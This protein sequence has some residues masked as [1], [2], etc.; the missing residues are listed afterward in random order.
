L[1]PKPT[2]D[3]SAPEQIHPAEPC[4]LFDGGEAWRFRAAGL[5]RSV[6]FWAIIFRDFF[7]LSLGQHLA[8]RVVYCVEDITATDASWTSDTNGLGEEVT[9]YRHLREITVFKTGGEPVKP[10]HIVFHAGNWMGDVET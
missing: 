1:L 2:E 6:D 3:S 4:P 9:L 5:V 10:G 7:Y 8:V